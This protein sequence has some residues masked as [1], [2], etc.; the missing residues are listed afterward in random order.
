MLGYVRGVIHV[1][2]E[3]WNE[4]ICECFAFEMSISTIIHS[5]RFRP[6]IDTVSWWRITILKNRMN[7]KRKPHFVFT[8]NPEKHSAPVNI[9]IS[10]LNSKTRCLE[11]YSD[12]DKYT[13]VSINWHIVC[14]RMV[15]FVADTIS[16]SVAHFESQTKKKMKSQT[17]VAITFSV[18]IT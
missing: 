8:I 6:C 18:K 16:V 13:F 12:N 3:K 10:K 17:F 7:K 1:S 15:H 2:N 9:V 4:P 11:S 14:T 5:P